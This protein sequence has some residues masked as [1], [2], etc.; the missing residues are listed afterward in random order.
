MLQGGKVAG[1]TVDELNEFFSIYLSILI[2]LGPAVYYAP[3]RN[4]YQKQK[5]NISRR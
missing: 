2:A 1:S 5:N 4:G 3:N